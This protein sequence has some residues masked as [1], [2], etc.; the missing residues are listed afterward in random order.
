MWSFHNVSV[1]LEQKIEEKLIKM[2]SLDLDLWID[3]S[4]IFTYLLWWEFDAFEGE[5]RNKWCRLEP[6]LEE[7]YGWLLQ[8]ASNY[9]WM[10]NMLPEINDN[11]FNLNYSRQ[12]ERSTH[13]SSFNQGWPQYLSSIRKIKD[14]TRNEKRK[15]V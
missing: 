2:K 14:A 1:K 8:E 7:K 11:T 9:L 4:M 10:N 15:N 12:R 6:F 13:F 3:I 5:F